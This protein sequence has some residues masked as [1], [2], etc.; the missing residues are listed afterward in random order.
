MTKWEARLYGRPDYL[1]TRLKPDGVERERGRVAAGL[2]VI[3]ENPVWFLGVMFQRAFSMLRLA[4]VE[5]VAPRPA[6]THALEVE[7]GATPT[8]SVAPAEF[9]ATPGVSADAHAPPAP[10]VELSPA[11]GGARARLAGE[12]KGAQVLAVSPPLAVA[13]RTDYLL[14]LPL[15]I[16]EGSVVLDV[17]DAR[18]GD[19]L[20]S[21]SV[22]HPVNYLEL[23]PEEQPAVTVQRPFVSGGAGEVRIALRSG[24]RRVARV[25]AEVGRAEVF[26][27]GSSAH[28]WTRVPRLFVRALQSFFLTAWML[29]LAA[30]G[31]ALLLR[32]GRRRELVV[33]LAVPAYYMCAQSALWTEFR[34]VLAMHYFLPILSAA[35]LHRLGGRLSGL[36]RLTRRGARAP[37]R[38]S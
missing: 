18:R 15:L 16:R 28:E 6:V 8:T 38:S 33:L 21:T 7:E 35:G 14:R 4:R 30:L 10:A 32:E 26:A 25:V 31:A 9:V 27:L 34:Y 17:L 24:S 3:R 36:A 37:L 20:A 19:V 2:K 23:K 13:P 22:L 29:P 5:T 11:A 12:A 1:G